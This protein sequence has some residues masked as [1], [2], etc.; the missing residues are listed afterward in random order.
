VLGD[1]ERL[2]QVFANLVGN[3]I[4]FTPQGG[5]VQIRVVARP[6]CV[7]FSVA[8]TGPGIADDHLRH[9]FD[10]YWRLHKRSR[11]GTGLGLSI[12][13]GI[14]EAH[15]GSVSVDTAPGAGA[16]FH[17]SLPHVG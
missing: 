7:Q 17:F 2:L 13:R 14:I 5:R 15:G 10:R 8:D 11:N 1:R 16:T 12:V 4:K 9:V 3:A 6:G